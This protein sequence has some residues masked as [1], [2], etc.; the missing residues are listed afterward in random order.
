MKEA[1]KPILDYGFTKM[2]LN[3]VEALIGA[4]NTPSLKILQ[5]NNFTFEGTLREHYNVNEVHEDS[6]L[7]SLLKSEAG[8]RK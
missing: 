8:Y 7:F 5:A 4:E 2:L 1:V 3:R 6:L